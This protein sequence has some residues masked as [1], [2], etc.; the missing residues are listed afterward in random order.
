MHFNVT[1]ATILFHVCPNL[2]AWEA[3]NARWDTSIRSFLPK[4]VDEGKV[5]QQMKC[6]VS[7][8][9]RTRSAGPACTKAIED[10]CKC[11][12]E[13]EWRKRSFSCLKECLRDARK[14]SILETK[15]QKLIGRSDSVKEN[16]FKVI[17]RGECMSRNPEDCAQ[18]IEVKNAT[19]GGSVGV[20]ECVSAK[21]CAFCSATTHYKIDGKCEECPA[22]P[23]LVIIGFILGIICVCA[24]MRWLDKR[25]FNLAFINIGWDYFQVLAM[26]TDCDVD[27]PAALKSLYRMLS[28]FSFDIDIV[29]PECLVP[30]FPYETKFWMVV[31][32]PII[33]GFFLVICWACYMCF[34]SFFMQRARDKLAHARFTAVFLLSWYYLYISVTRRALEIFNC[35]PLDPDDGLLYT[36]FTSFECDSGPCECGNPRHVQVR[37]VTPAIFAIVYMT[38]G[39][40]IVILFLLRKKKTLIKEDQLLRA[41]DTG[42]SIFTNPRSF[43]L[44]T[45]LHKMYFYFKP[46]KT[47]WIIVIILR[48]MLICVAALMFRANPGFQLAFVLLVLFICYV[49]QVKHQPYMSTVSLYITPSGIKANFL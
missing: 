14:M 30:D 2:V 6:S 22:N 28:F 24:F 33:L 16:M 10:V 40:P 23:E 13:W 36:S 1:D 9:C 20:C 31:L 17:A 8:Q 25:R 4:K 26:F 5:A 19:G 7:L 34:N 46:G 11:P 32:S 41:H 47:Y 18:C 15:C 39:F 49:V 35:N 44:R 45:W 27:W 21:R 29:A 42:D 43:Y 3:I 12:K 38:V 48:K 37:L